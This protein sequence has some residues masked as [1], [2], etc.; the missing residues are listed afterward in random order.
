MIKYC[1]VVFFFCCVFSWNYQHLSEVEFDLS[2]EFEDP[3][4]LKV[5]MNYQ[6]CKTWEEGFC[7]SCADTY[8]FNKD[9]ICIEADP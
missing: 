6:G 1:I 3:E 8:Y 7:V 2:S 9:G 4:F 5:V